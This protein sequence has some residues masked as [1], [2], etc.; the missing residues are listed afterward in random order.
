MRVLL[1]QFG[2]PTTVLN[3][4][5][6]GAWGALR[7]A[8]AQPLGVRGGGRGLLAGDFVPL[9]GDPPAWLRTTPGAALGS[10]RQALDGAA[11]EACARRLRGEG[12]LAVVVM[13]G[14]GTMA[15]GEGLARAG[16][17]VVGV[18]KTIDN[19]LEGT[20]HAPGYPSAA[21]FV[22]DA[23][24]DLA[25]DLRAMAGF[26]DVRLI[27]V[28]GR[29]AGWLAAAATLAR[30][31]TGGLPQLVLLPEVPLDAEAFC[32][33]VARLQRRDGSVLIAVAEGVRTTEGLGL[34][35]GALDAAGRTPVLGGAAHRLAALLRTRLG[36]RVRA[37]SLGFLPRCLRA[38]AMEGDRA[39]AEGAGRA[40]AAA[41]LAGRGGVMVSIPPRPEGGPAS[42]YGMVPLGEVA[43]RERLLPPGMRDGEAFATWLRPLLGS[44]PQPTRLF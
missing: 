21:A 30:A 6:Y 31:A 17:C 32:A 22:V 27:E 16:L 33:E 2:G 5:L 15:L 1:G 8:G 40:A 9:T 28:M 3:A 29:R 34:G 14:N 39:E 20:D 10:G 25:V 19:D 44:I 38:A 4:S 37:E 12:V 24:T 26:E 23:F 13:G 7:A 36:L 18:P 42:D 43:G 35:E 11:L 41:V